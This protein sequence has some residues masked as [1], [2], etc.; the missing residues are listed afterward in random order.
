MINLGEAENNKKDNLITLYPFNG[1]SPYLIDKFYIIGYNYLTFEKLLI[2]NTPKSL[3]EDEKEIK[4]AKE[5]TKK[6]FEFE[7]EPTILNEISNDYCKETL[8]TKTILQMIFPHKSKCYYTWEENNNL[9]KRTVLTKVIDKNDIDNFQK[10]EFDESEGEFI[11]NERIVFSSN[12]Q[13]A[14]N[15]KKSINGLAHTFYRKFMKKK[16]LGKKKY[17]YYVPYTFCIIS[18]YPFYSSFD[19]LI[20]CIKKIYSQESIYI[21]I[22][23]I[24]YNI[25]SLTP[26]PLNS[27]ILLDLESSCEQEKNFGD[28]KG[29]LINSLRH[30]NN[31]SEKG[32]PINF[33]VE[34]GN[35]YKS[36]KSN[37]NIRNNIKEEEKNK[38][39]FPIQLPF[40][41]T[42]TT[43]QM[44]MQNQINSENDTYKIEFKFL[45]GYPLIQYNLPKILFSNL[46]I[47]K[48]ITI[49]L[50]MFLEK[51]VLF[52]SKDAEYLTLSLNAFLN[53]NFPLNDEKYYFLGAAIS[54]KDFIEGNSE[55]GLK[56]YTS[57][58]GINDSFRPDYRS[59]NIKIND[60]LVVDLDKGEIIQGEE[61]K[62]KITNTDKNNKKLVNLIER[63]CKENYEDEKTKSIT[64]YQ[65]IKNIS[66]KLKIIIEKYEQ[67]A[68][69]IPGDYMD[70]YDK[71]PLNIYLMNREI[72]ESF[73][74]FVN[75]LC[76]YFYENLTIESNDD[77]SKNNKELKM[78]V[79]FD[80][81]NRA[82]TKHE[83]NEDEKLFL[84]ELKTTMKYQSFVFIFLQSYNPIDLYKIPLTFTEEFLAIILQKKE[85]IG[86]NTSRVKFFI[87][88]K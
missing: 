29:D 78:S 85:E 47:E 63:M 55:F 16:T 26:S 7:E 72:Q 21:P 74:E 4:E 57:I 33:K 84:E 13:T 24:I 11:K 3:I 70:F 52:F 1:R 35:N 17:T 65:A 75:N 44:V 37:K 87:M 28:I 69:I 66:K 42:I 12:P 86:G 14:N 34:L 80:D 8:D 9:L 71:P 68:K 2:K 83:Y 79:I 31:P 43:T 25:I 73:Y 56:N 38:N 62:D 54:L 6:V 45:S 61:I 48:I 20:K 60:H 40:R 50:Y 82:N 49:F 10:I 36:F 39:I 18:E 67:Y 53:L 19:K 77:K 64:L 76:L 32:I 58:I 81:E 23:I 46:T 51:D 15:S 41:R 59:K 88:C 5:I 27:D 30:K 22:E